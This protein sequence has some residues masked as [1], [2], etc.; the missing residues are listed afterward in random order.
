MPPSPTPPSLPLEPLAKSGPDEG[1]S[2]ATH[3]R[4]VARYAHAVA[5]AY[6]PHWQ[7]IL[8][9]GWAERIAQALVLAALTHDLGKLAEGFQRSLRRRS[10]W[11]F[12]HEVLSA[13][14]LLAAL[15]TV[16]DTAALALAAILTHHRDLTDPQLLSNAGAGVASL[17]LPRL[18]EQ[19]R[20]IFKQKVGELKH[21][22]AWLQKFVQQHPEL[23]RLRPPPTPDLIHPPTRFLCALQARATSL[24]ELTTPEAMALVLTRGWLMAA[25]HAASA[26]VTDFKAHLSVPVLPPAR[27]FQ[28]QVGTHRGH[29][30]LEAPTGSGK[31][32]AALLWALGNRQHGE[33][34]FYLLPYQ[35]SI[36]AMAGTLAEQLGSEMVATL[37]ARAL[38]YAFREHFERTGE[39]E[40]AYTLARTEVDLDRIVH[41]PLKVA[42]PFQLLKWL[43]G[44]PRFE[45]GLSE[46]VGGIFIFDEIHAYEPNV[47]ALINEMVRI[48]NK[49]GGKFL[50]MSATFPQ[51]LKE[52]FIQTLD[53]P[54]TEYSLTTVSDR[55]TSLFLHQTRHRI[56]WHAASLEDLLPAILRAAE[57][58]Q[59]V[60]VV[61]N[62]VA[63]AQEIY[64]HLCR[65]LPGVHLL[66]GRFSHR[67]RVQK[68]QTVIGALQGKRHDPVRVLVATQVVEVS[69]DI[70]FDTLFTEVAPV[71][72]LLQRFGRV[73]RYGEHAGGV[74]VHVAQGFHREKLRRVY[75]LERVTSTLQT[76]PPDNTPLSFETIT[77]WI[78]EVYRTGLTPK[79]QARFTQA[80]T[81]FQ[82]ILGALRPLHHL[83]EGEEEFYGLF[84]SIEV[85]PRSLFEEYQTYIDSKRYLL[86]MQLMVSIPLGTYHI[87]QRSG[88]LHLIKDRI[89]LADARY[90]R[91][92]GLTADDVDVDINFL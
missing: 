82:T 77:H 45:I 53:T 76:A 75:D 20:Q 32:I 56:R 90:D 65:H 87:L 66:H 59:R 55:W 39:Y 43:F 36:E 69:L 83:A 70:S 10:K 7:K 71:D 50:F 15:E 14:I 26:G 37:H 38:D 58:G 54:I 84:H 41:K 8:P 52:L 89:L 5:Q 23:H 1:V 22:W 4:A 17:P 78:G 9:T 44:I 2:L 40:T 72:D 92:L 16:D 6:H 51:F 3:L 49:L 46:M 67:D 18:E 11:E 48:L 31:T 88:R 86:A 33:R 81:A 30:I 29:A 27:A 34:I 25:D 21:Y 12:R 42:T 73:N 47:I 68:E 28:Q 57:S 91:E 64:R 80:Q 63:Q 85:L 13:A 62:R 60:L 61:A 35:A 24:S 19:V 74:E 79:E